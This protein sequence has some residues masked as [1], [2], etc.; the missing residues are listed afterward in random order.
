MYNSNQGG[1]YNSNIFNNNNS[2]TNR[3]K[4][5]FYLRILAGCIGGL[6]ILKLILGDYNGFN[7][8]LMTSLFIFLTTF[9]INPFL[10]GFL[11]IS[12]LFSVII[13]SV[14]FALQ[15][16][17]AIFDIPVPIQKNTLIFLYVINSLG[18]IFYTFAIY[19]CYKF[20]SESL[21]NP[22]F[23]SGGYSLLND[24]P[25]TQARAYSGMEPSERQQPQSN[26]RAFSGTGFRLDA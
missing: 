4:N 8:D 1:N 20:Y 13:T 11:T 12:L 2:N 21:Y 17:N 25:A 7:S 24:N 23:N 16:Q 6:A 22:S 19:Y 10:A 9:C 3:N 26:F 15:I 14:F 18:M 5:L